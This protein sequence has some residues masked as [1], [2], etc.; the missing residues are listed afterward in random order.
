M[1][2]EES[3]RI[4]IRR[5]LI[6]KGLTFNAEVKGVPVITRS[7]DLDVLTDAIIEYIEKGDLP[8][9]LMSE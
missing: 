4:S 6:N 8:T 2:P 7:V 9:S 5:H 1:T 3:I